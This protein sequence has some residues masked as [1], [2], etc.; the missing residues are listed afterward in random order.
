[1]KIELA[2]HSGFCTGVKDAVNRIVD[3]INN[4]DENIF[5]Q[6]PIIHSPQTVK[7]LEKRGLKV[8]KEKDTVDNK[9]AAIRT[10]GTTRQELQDIKKRAKRVINLTCPNVA[11]V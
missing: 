3:E 1:M 8:I 9:I 11:H 2:K 5:I 7:I 4:C 6:G 10:H